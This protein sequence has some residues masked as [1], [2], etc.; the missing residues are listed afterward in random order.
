MTEEIREVYYVMVSA[1]V[2]QTGT[3]AIAARSLEHA[4]EIVTD[5]YKNYQDFKILDA[6]KLKDCPEVL[7]AAQKQEAK[8]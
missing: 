6:F 1:M 5:K 7:Q 3:E 2:P 8:V 4:K